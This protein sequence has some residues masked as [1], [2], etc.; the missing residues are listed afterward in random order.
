MQKIIQCLQ[1]LYIPSFQIS[2]KMDI[3]CKS[4]EQNIT[5]PRPRGQ[6]IGQVF[7]AITLVT[8]K[9]EYNIYSYIMNSFSL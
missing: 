5:C 3:Q 2:C 6:K 9:F 4:N 1:L 7:F 8:N